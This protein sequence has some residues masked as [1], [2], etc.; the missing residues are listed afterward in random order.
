VCASRRGFLFDYCRV[1]NRYAFRKCFVCMAIAY[2]VTL[3]AL[4]AQV[5]QDGMTP[6][7]SSE[8][9]ELRQL[10]TRMPASLKPRRLH[11]L[12]L[13][14]APRPQKKSAKAWDLTFCAKRQL[15]SALT[16]IMGTTSTI[17]LAGSI[18]C[19]LMT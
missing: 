14:P 9:D 5:A 7:L 19:A 6:K 13:Q 12:L 11:R 10:Q 15:R 4:S 8:S 17:L 18:C 2:A 16:A 1:L 3:P